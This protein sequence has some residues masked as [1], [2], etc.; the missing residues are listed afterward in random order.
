MNAGQ[1]VKTP[2][3]LFAGKY[4]IER[5]LGE[6]G[7][8]EVHLAVHTAMGNRV[9]IKTLR[10][11][12]LADETAVER[13]NREARAAVSL[14]SEHVARVLDVGI[15]SDGEPYMVMEY[16]EGA[17]LAAVMRQ[18]GPLPV[19]EAIDYVLQ[20]CEAIAEAHA[21]GIVHRDLKPANLFVTRR[22][23]GAALVK[24]LDFGISKL[25]A[26]AQQGQAGSLTRTA[27][28]MGSPSYMSPEQLRS[29]RDVDPRGDIWALGVILYE[30]LS[31][32]LPFIAETLTELTIKVVSDLPPPIQTLRPDVAPHLAQVIDRCLRKNRDERFPNVGALAAEIERYVTTDQDSVARRIARMSATPAAAASAPPP[33]LSSQRIGSGHTNISWGET[34][35]ATNA[36]PTPA[37]RAGAPVGAIVLFALAGLALVGAGGVALV[38]YRSSAKPTGPTAPPTVSAAA[39]PSAGLLPDERTQLPPIPSASVAA[40]AAVPSALPTTRQLPATQAPV[41]KKPPAAPSAKATAR[42][43]NGMPDER[44]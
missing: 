25:A 43:D 29:S 14:K 36:G 6:G 10:K 16:L 7:M 32:H 18:R 44:K 23:D 33:P 8:G 28:I 4:V 27:T 31:G 35:L 41:G 19:H 34:S 2:S 11:E 26:D 13:F 9:A 20:A 1:T 12:T 21:I 24:V 42:P 37:R 15:S 40:S 39:P 5:Q 3:R 17:D 30:L 22:F 38:L